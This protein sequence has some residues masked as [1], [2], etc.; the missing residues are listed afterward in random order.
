MDLGV[1]NTEFDYMLGGSSASIITL[2]VEDGYYWEVEMTGIK[3]SEE[4]ADEW[5]F[6]NTK[7]RFASGLQCIY[8]PPNHYELMKEEVLKYSM[9]YYEDSTYG[10]VV[11][12]NQAD[13][14][15]PM[16]I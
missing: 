11:D 6:S 12:C 14:L 16:K 9:G 13:D 5:G 10:I 2:A 3:F 7:A 4:S 1:E 8:A 15:Y